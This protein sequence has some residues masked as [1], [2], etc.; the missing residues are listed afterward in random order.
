MK[1]RKGPTRTGMALSKEALELIRV[2]RLADEP[3][4][5]DCER[6]HAAIVAAVRGPRA[7]RRWGAP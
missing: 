6:V 1:P 3:D 2:A 7:S 4:Q 5:A